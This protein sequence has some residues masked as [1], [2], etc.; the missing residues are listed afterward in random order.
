MSH[1]TGP[2]LSFSTCDDL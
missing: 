2:C 1:I